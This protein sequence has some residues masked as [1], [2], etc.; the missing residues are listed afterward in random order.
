MSASLLLPRQPFCKRP[1]AARLPKKGVPADRAW[2]RLVGEPGLGRRAATRMFGDGGHDQLSGGLGI[3]LVIGNTASDTFFGDDGED[4]MFGNKGNDT[5]NCG[6]DSDLVRGGV[7]VDIVDPSAA[8]SS[9]P[10][11]R[12]GRP[13]KLHPF[14]SWPRERCVRATPTI[15]LRRSLR[16]PGASSWPPHIAVD[17]F[18]GGEVLYQ[19]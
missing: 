1:R 9:R 16:S 19:A 13:R 10:E 18:T 5:F 3:D 12:N 4:M 14:P 15:P 8:A 11:Y 17:V 6:P 2:R 7:G